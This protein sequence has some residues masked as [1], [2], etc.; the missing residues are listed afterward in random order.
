MSSIAEIARSVSVSM[1]Y[2]VTGA[3]VSCQVIGGYFFAG[4]LPADG[5]HGIVHLVGCCHQCFFRLGVH[6]RFEDAQ[7]IASLALAAV[8]RSGGEAP[9]G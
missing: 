9:N 8:L 4:A 3:L 5:I 2:R 1:K 6:R 7:H